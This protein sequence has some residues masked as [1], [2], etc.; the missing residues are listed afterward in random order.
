MDVA[1]GYIVCRDGWI[2]NGEVPES[3]AI[4]KY[5]L[6]PIGSWSKKYNSRIQCVSVVLVLLLSYTEIFA[7]FSLSFVLR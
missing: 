7:F 6:R 2:S 4:T 3:S 1:G 5:V